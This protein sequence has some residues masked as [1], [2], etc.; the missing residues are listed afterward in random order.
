M[1]EE[2]V[3]RYVPHLRYDK[4]E[5]FFPEAIGYTVFRESGWSSSCRLF[6][7]VKPEETV[8]EYAFY[9][10]FDIQHQ[11]DLEHVFVKINKSGEILGVLGS[12]HGKFLNN[13]IPGET[14]FE[15][16]H[17]I[18][19]VQPGKHAFMPNPH[20][21]QLAPDRNENCNLYAGSDGLLIAPMFEGR[22]STEEAFDEKVKQY[23]RHHFSFE[24]FWEFDVKSVGQKRTEGILRPWEELYELIVKRIDE[25]KSKIDRETV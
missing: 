19:Y 13:L 15:G 6:I 1:T 21:F 16:T 25:W 18:E 9:Y 4:N 23:I 5:P 7:R 17:V 8:L 12:F 2:L 10:D 24:P 11:Y 3:K 22:L 14:A 20:Y